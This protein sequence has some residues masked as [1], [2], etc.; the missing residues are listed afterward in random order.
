MRP[1]HKEGKKIDSIKTYRGKP[2]LEALEERVSEELVTGGSGRGLI[3]QRR[4]QEVHGVW[5]DLGQLHFEG[6]QVSHVRQL[7]APT[8]G[9]A[10]P[11]KGQEKRY[12]TSVDR[13]NSW[14]GARV[15]MRGWCVCD[16]T[17]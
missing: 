12:I 1:T 13:D 9:K 7:K 16:M 6:I 3:S 15:S 10:G 8:N 4:L 2:L 11:D 5:V 14:Y 17:D